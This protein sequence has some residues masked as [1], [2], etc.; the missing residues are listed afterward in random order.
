MFSTEQ[1]AS[2]VHPR[3]DWRTKGWES[4]LAGWLLLPTPSKQGERRTINRGKCY[5]ALISLPVLLPA[6]LLLQQLDKKL[7]VKRGE[8]LNSLPHNQRSYSGISTRQERKGCEICPFSGPILTKGLAR[9]C[10]TV[11]VFAS[12]AYFLPAPFPPD[13]TPLLLAHLWD[14]G[15]LLL[16]VQEICCSCCIRGLESKASFKKKKKK[17]AR[18]EGKKHSS[19]CLQ[20]AAFLFVQTR[21]LQTVCL[22]Q[23]YPWNIRRLRNSALQRELEGLERFGIVHLCLQSQKSIESC[24]FDSFRNG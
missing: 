21:I 12:P 7:K 15:G 13:L 4:S 11:C 16:S 9:R 2:A 22:L 20:C 3:S 10:A 23:E 14:I 1:Y 5:G 24:I 17:A 6:L 18:R 19:Q 8:A